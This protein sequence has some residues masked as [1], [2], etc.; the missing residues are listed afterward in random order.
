MQLKRDAGLRKKA[1]GKV[2]LFKVV[3]HYGVLDGAEHHPN[4]LRVLRPQGMQ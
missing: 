1:S 2:V 3:L 4:V